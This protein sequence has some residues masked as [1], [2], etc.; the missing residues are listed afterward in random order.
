M[1]DILYAYILSSFRSDTQ[2]VVPSDHIPPGL[3]FAVSSVNSSA[4]SLALLDTLKARTAVLSQPVTH[5]VMPSDHIPMGWVTPLLMSLEE[6]LEPS[7]NR[8]P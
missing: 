1:S 6:S 3:A 4:V 2:I 7:D 5:M 8:Y